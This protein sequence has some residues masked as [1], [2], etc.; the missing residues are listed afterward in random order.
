MNVPAAPTSRGG[1]ARDLSTVAVFTILGLTVMVGLWSWFAG[2]PPSPPFL[3]RHLPFGV[4][5]GF[6]IGVPAFRLIPLVAARVWH[7]HPV[8][9][10]SALVATLIACAVG[11]T[12]IAA[13]VPSLVGMPPEMIGVVFRENIRGT[14][15]TT[16]VGGVLLAIFGSTKARLEATELALRTH[17]LER[18][19]AET[20][21]VEARLASLASRVQPHFLF[22]TLNAIS[23]LIRENPVLA[24]RTVERLSSLMRAS[25]DP[26]D[27]IPLEQELK[28]ATDYL[29]IQRTRLQ[30]RLRYDVSMALDAHAAVPPFS[31]QTLVENAVTH[32]AGQRPTGVNVRISAARSGDDV[33]VD[34]IDDG[35]GFDADAMK[36]GR[37]LDMVRSRLRALYGERADLELRREPGR[38]TVRMRVPSA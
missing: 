16:V 3:L 35:A 28:L 32:V 8:H 25:L 13:A 4:V 19:R 1:W 30:D 18:E 15:A 20:T 7:R 31:V 22:N 14:L 37:G 26:K 5:L 33:V 9:R 23:A 10:W 29:E 34:V 21:A 11:G 27:V 17:Q 36:A 2:W 38:M 6:A 12:A 24:E